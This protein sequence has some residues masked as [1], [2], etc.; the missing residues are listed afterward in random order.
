MF[1]V[2][3]NRN[4]SALLLLGS[5]TGEEEQEHGPLFSIG[6][7]LAALCPSSHPQDSME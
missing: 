6:Y 2:F 7:V 4:T 1:F 3:Q 5:G